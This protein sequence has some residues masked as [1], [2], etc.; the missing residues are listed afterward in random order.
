MKSLFS[1]AI[2]LLLVLGVVLS[3]GPACWS[4]KRQFQFEQFPVN[5]YQG[6]IKIPQGLQKGDDGIWRDDLGKWVADLEVTYAGEYYLAG[7][8]CGALCRYY[9][10]VNLRTG[11]DM[12]EINMFAC[13]E[14]R[15]LTK[16]GH[17]YI[18]HL[19][20]QPDSRLLIAE[21]HLDFEDPNRPE[22]CRQ[23]YFVL[24]NGKLRPISKTF[25]FCTEE[26]E[27]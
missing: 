21:Y 2:Q 18:T 13:A 3:A 24:E 6:P 4:Q 26:D 11:V 7:H 1:N 10:L 14:P 16:K 23:R 19:F 17:S 25:L 15:P 9:Q 5:V 8:S 20:Y 27:Q 22:T 12:P